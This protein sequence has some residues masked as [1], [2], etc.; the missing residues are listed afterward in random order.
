MDAYLNSLRMTAEQ[1][2]L[3]R[4][5]TR[6]KTGKYFWTALIFVLLFQIYNISYAL[7]YTNF[8]LASQA[9]KVYMTLYILMLLFCVASAGAGLLLA[10]KKEA[11]P[12]R[13]LGLYS[14]F[15]CAL[16]L[17]S[18][19]I[20]LY[21]Q[22][23]SNNISVYMTSAIYVAGLIYMRPR[24]SVPT[25][26]LCETVLLAVLLPLQLTGSRDT[27]GTCVNSFGVTLV[28]LFISLYRWSSLRRD[29]L[30]QLEIEEKNKM[31][32]EQSEK[33]NYIANH[34]PLTGLWN[35]NYLNE[36]KENFYARGSGRQAA[37]FII[38]IDYFKDYNDAFGHVAGDQCLKKVA[39][40]L[41]ELNPALFRF[42]GEEF[43][44]LLPPEELSRADRLAEDFCRHIE[45]QQLPSVKLKNYLTVSVGYSTGTM[46]NDRE[47]RKLL[48]EADLA[49]YQA[50]DSGRNQAIKYTPR[51]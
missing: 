29:F 13:L 32:L 23:V 48:H 30:N 44:C 2:Q 39:S 19:C 22:R 38:D 35:R 8:R 50:K 1:E 47:F 31:I 11:D 25:F 16:V 33:L 6:K 20:T 41:L 37:V 51:T 5:K 26:L 14:L 17:W 34:D 36:W 27:Y 49:L 43:L 10:S 42:G 21:D 28:S 12:S 3:F 40:A 4:K 9:S 46:T 45:A 24:A 18:A 7:Y 15:G